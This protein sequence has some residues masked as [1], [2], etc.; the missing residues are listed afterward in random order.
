MFQYFNLRVLMHISKWKAIRLGRK[1]IWH[2]DNL[3]TYAYCVE[4]K[5][6]EPNRTNLL[7]KPTRRSHQK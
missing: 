4:I 7:E 2:F 5:Q 6:E 3:I 1:V